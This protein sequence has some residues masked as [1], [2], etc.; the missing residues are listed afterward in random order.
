[1]EYTSILKLLA[2]VNVRS[3][4]S[5]EHLQVRAFLKKEF[6]ASIL[7]MTCKKCNEDSFK[8]SKDKNKIMN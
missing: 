6:T 1:M 8:S 5:D 4:T 3:P 7:T 2:G